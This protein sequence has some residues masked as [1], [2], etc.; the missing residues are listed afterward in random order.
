MHR[1]QIVNVSDV[2]RELFEFPAENIPEGITANNPI[3]LH[4]PEPAHIFD[5]MLLGAGY[6]G[7]VCK[8]Q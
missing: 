4:P 3:V 6:G 1:S 5:L 2:F 8:L 7:F